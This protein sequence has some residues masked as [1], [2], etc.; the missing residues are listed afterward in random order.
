MLITAGTKLLS[1]YYF[2]SINGVIQV[3]VTLFEMKDLRIWLME[4][5]GLFVIPNQLK[6]RPTY[7]SN[8]ED[9]RRWKDVQLNVSS[10]FHSILIMILGFIYSFIFF[11]V[12]YLFHFFTFE[13]R[14]MILN[15]WV[16]TFSIDI[17]SQ[18]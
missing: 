12:N 17:F 9:N 15:F 14:E 7:S 18:L 6:Y 8:L 5:A 3:L 1:D 10:N 13:V 11:E 4:D 2:K 16:T